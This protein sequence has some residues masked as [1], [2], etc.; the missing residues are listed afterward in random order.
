MLALTILI[1]IGIGGSALLRVLHPK[2]EISGMGNA[3]LALLAVVF[4]IGW[5]SKVR[6]SRL[7]DRQSGA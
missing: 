7:N 2:D 4:L 3:V 5:A 6:Q 1:P